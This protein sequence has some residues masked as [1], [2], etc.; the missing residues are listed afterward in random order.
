MDIVMTFIVY[1]IIYAKKRTICRKNKNSDSRAAFTNRILCWLMKEVHSR[2][3][4]CWEPF[5]KH[6][7]KNI[8]NLVS[9]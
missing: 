2:E 9:I 5:L 8:A 3:V 4:K 7:A 1:Y 6:V